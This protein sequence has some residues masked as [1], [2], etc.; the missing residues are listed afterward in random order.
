MALN[1]DDGKMTVTMSNRNGAYVL[2]G[3]C[4]PL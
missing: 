4:T 1:S 3:S 2:F